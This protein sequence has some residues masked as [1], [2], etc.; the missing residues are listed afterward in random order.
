MAQQGEAGAYYNQPYQQQ[1]P[2]G[3]AQY[4]PPTGPPQNYQQFQQGPAQPFPPM[5]QGPYDGKQIG[6]Q[7][8]PMYGESFVPPMDDKQTF[9]DTFK[10][11]KPKWNDLWAG[12]LLLA[13]FFGFVAVSGLSLYRYSRYQGFNGGGIYGAGNDFSLN[14]NTLVLFIFV[15]VVAFVLSWAYFLLARAFTKQFIWITG[16]LN[17]VIAVGTAVYYLYRRLWGAG[18]VFAIF[19][20]FA[21]FCFISWIPRIPFAVVMLQQAQDVARMKRVHVFMVSFVGGLVATVFAAWFS[22]TL[23]GIYTAYMPSNANA[24]SNPACAQ[25]GG[26]SSG[27]VIGL[28]VFVTFAAYWI[29]EWIKNT[30]HTVIAGVYGSWYFCAGKPGGI[31]RGA[32]MGSFKRA[33]TYSFGSISLGSLVVALIN[34]LRQACSIAQN[35]SAQD[36]NIIG[37]IFFCI[38]GCLIGILNWL[39]EFL[40]RYA[41]S[42]IALYGKAYIPAAKDTWRMMKDRG[43]DAL[44]NDCLTGPVLSMGSIFVAYVCALLSYLYLE[45]THPAYNE[46]RTFTPVIMAFSFLIGLQICQI[47]MTPISSGIDTIFVA[48]GWDPDVAVREHPEFWQKLVQVYPHVQ[49]VIHA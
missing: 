48:M 34:M 16:I 49:D 40:N 2:Q 3:Y 41:F 42:H 27:K 36:G 6:Q 44:I 47:F 20:V 39:V 22:I 12:L 4:Q 9:Q 17:C 46:S 28:V 35:Q 33:T 21:I 11:Q 30:V 19:A 13:T 32:T 26:C 31:P 25:L 14:T 24:T 29:S 23:V 38:L 10:I 7:N 8:P 1:Q 18:I 37:T 43:L 15:I 5:Q 45:F